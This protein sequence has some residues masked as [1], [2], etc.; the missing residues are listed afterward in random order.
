M[1]KETVVIESLGK[2]GPK[3]NGEYYSFSKKIQESDKGK[4]VPGGTF[5]LDIWTA[6]SGKKYIN[7]VV[8]TVSTGTPKVVVAMRKE[9]DALSKANAESFKKS[10]TPKAASSETMTKAEWSAKDRS[11]LI[12]GLSHDAATLVAA[13]VTANVPL[14][15]VLAQ[16][17]T[18]LKALLE[19]RESV[20]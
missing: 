19:V 7:S 15:D 4:L 20:K 2:W 11:Q 6:E 17:G 1:S 14:E 13:S 9:I 5:D 16:F 8:G 18:A 3:I 12:G 10:V